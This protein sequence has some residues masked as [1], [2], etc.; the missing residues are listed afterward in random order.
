MTTQNLH[1]SMLYCIIII[2]I[3]IGSVNCISF[4][5]TNK[6]KILNLSGDRSNS[7]AT[8]QKF[9]TRRFKTFINRSAPEVLLE[10]GVLKTCSKFTGEHPCRSVIII[11]LQSNYKILV[12]SQLLL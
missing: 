5:L 8:L 9:G 4:W 11:K 3:F 2:I 12:L 6:K 7:N 1:I 10:E